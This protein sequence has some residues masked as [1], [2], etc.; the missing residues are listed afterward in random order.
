MKRL[1]SNG[2]VAGFLKWTKHG[3]VL[4]QALFLALTVWTTVRML[5]GV[6]GATIERYCPFG[7]VET[8]I[9]WIKKTGTLCSLSTLN[10]SILVGVLVITVLFKRVQSKPVQP[11][12]H[13]QFQQERFINKI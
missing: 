11:F 4:S 3:R 9:P 13:A 1:G 5:S 2:L 7:G 8:L 10:I 6:R 12:F